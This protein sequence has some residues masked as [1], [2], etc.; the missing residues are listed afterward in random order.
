MLSQCCHVEY[1]ASANRP[2]LLKSVL[3][4]LLQQYLLLGRETNSDLTFTSAGGLIPFDY[5]GVRIARMKM[6]RVRAVM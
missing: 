6:I 5:F 4:A 2:A 1:A 3:L